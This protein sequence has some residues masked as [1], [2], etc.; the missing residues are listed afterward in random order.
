MRAMLPFIAVLGAIL[1]TGGAS[2]Q[3]DTQRFMVS[4]ASGPVL[5]ESFGSCGRPT[6]PAVIVLSGSKGFASPAYGDI[7]HT[8]RAAGLEAY[9]VHVLSRT[10]LK[11]IAMASGAQAR[12]AFYARR[13]PDWTASVRRVIADLQARPSHSRKI[14][15]LG[16]S[17]GAEIASSASVGQTDIGA[18]VLVDGGLPTGYAQPIR[19][20]PPLLLIWGHADRTFPVSVGRD[21]E[22]RARGLGGSASLK[23]YEGGSHDFFLQAGN[24]TAGRAQ[25]D[26]AGFLTA[27]LAQ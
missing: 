23:I 21:L 12:I 6:C 22:Q 9:L 15:V 16:V 26:T 17:L 27:L 5:V 11:A 25:R 2:A 3:S 19:S 10:D 7:G 1:L 20:L 24:Q 8:L 4:A 14:G 18:L 13:L